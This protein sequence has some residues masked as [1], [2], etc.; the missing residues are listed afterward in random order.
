MAHLAI[1]AQTSQQGTEASFPAPQAQHHCNC[2]ACLQ[3]VRHERPF[4]LQLPAARHQALELCGN[5]L[6]CLRETGLIL[7]GD[8][9][10]LP[11][12]AAH[13]D[14]KLQVPHASVGFHFDRPSCTI[15]T[16]HQELH[17]GPVVQ[18]CA[19]DWEI[20]GDLYRTALH[21]AKNVKFSSDCVI[22]SG[23][24]RVAMVVESC[25]S[26]AGG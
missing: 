23:Y 21:H 18:R 20:C 12:L 15:Q 16:S 13:L 4:V 8:H 19:V 7:G 10:R 3:S 1:S 11:G 14:S 5:A 26:L 22:H 24:V 25:T 17:H 9:N 2:A 6:L